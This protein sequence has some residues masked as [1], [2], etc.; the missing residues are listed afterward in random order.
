MHRC[1]PYTI[2]TQSCASRTS[3]KGK[4]ED[5]KRPKTII[6][7]HL[8]IKAKPF[9]VRKVVAP[10]IGETLMNSELSMKCT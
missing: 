10:Y 2:I 7:I 4:T 8:K 6:A 3:T 9:P 1:H 5:Y